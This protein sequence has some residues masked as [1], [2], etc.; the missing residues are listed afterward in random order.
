MRT[1][2]AGLTLIL[3]A[4]ILQPAPARADEGAIRSVIEGQIA[5]FRAD[6]APGAWSYAAPSIKG[7]FGN[8]QRFMSMVRQGYPP[9][10]RPRDYAFG[11]L[12]QAPGGP[13]QEV[14]IVD[15]AGVSWVALYS[16]EQQADGTW[17]ISGCQLLRRP[18][19]NA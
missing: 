6:D 16:L 15:E 3:A 11:E 13:L 8:E 18:G 12:R 7:M 5:A 4:A 14:F 1:L 9:V 10:Y 2:L 17:K 19:L